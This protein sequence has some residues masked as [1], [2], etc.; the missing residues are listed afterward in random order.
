[1]KRWLFQN[2]NECGRACQG[3]IALGREGCSY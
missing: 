1:L 3:A 2:G